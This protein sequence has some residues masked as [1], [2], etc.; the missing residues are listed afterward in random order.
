MNKTQESQIKRLVDLKGWKA[1][2][3]HKVLGPIWKAVLKEQK[4]SQD[5]LNCDWN[6]PKFHR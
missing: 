1:V 2:K 6:A 3:E 4:R 5:S